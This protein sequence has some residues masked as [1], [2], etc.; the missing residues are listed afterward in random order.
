MKYNYKMKSLFDNGHLN[1]VRSFKNEQNE[2][3]W[4]SLAFH[5]VCLIVNCKLK[6]GTGLNDKTEQINFNL[7]WSKM[8]F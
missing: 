7:F 8:C 3:Q 6:F 2:F 4:F 1:D 5:F